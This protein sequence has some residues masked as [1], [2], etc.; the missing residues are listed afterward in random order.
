MYNSLLKVRYSTSHIL[1]NC[2]D[3]LCGFEAQN[4]KFSSSEWYWFIKTNENWLKSSKNTGKQQQKNS[5]KTLS[6][7][8]FVWII[9]TSISIYSEWVNFFGMVENWMR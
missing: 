5:N 4:I 3:D 9:Q 1:K 8:I 6:S 2:S 7:W